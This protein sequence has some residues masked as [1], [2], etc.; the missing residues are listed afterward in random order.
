VGLLDGI[1]DNNNTKAAIKPRRLLI[2]VGCAS[3]QRKFIIHILAA[4]KDLVEQ[5]KIQ[6]FLNA[7]DHK[8]HAG[9]V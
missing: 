5:N 3:A 9:G 6:L 2:P 7:G 1:D 8:A 4:L